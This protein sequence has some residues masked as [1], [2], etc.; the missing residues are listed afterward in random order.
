MTLK[1]AVCSKPIVT[2][3]VSN[4]EYACRF[5]RYSD[6]GETSNIFLLIIFKP[7]E[8]EDA[9]KLPKDASNKHVYKLSFDINSLKIILNLIYFPCSMKTEI[10][11][12]I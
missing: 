7:Y 3:H 4:Q 10:L 5:S 2:R 12:Y 6:L 9:S 11:N 8:S 1:T